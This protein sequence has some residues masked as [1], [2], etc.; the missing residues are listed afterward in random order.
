MKFKHI[1]QQFHEVHH[2]HKFTWI[3]ST[4]FIIQKSQKSQLTQKHLNPQ[5]KIRDYSLIMK[6]KPSPLPLVFKN[7]NFGFTL[8]PS[9]SNSK[10][11]L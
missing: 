8:S 1:T 4:I 5:L 2:T 11:S 9:S 6:R 3:R 10:L 7:P